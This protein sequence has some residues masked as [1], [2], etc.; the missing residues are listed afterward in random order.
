MSDEAAT[1]DR[2]SAYVDQ[3]RAQGRTARTLGF[4]ACL[5]GVMVLA[6]GRFRFG[7][8]AWMLWTGAAVVAVGWGLFVYALLRRL[9]WVRAHPFD[10]NG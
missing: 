2:Q 4:I 6:L 1:L 10:P 3:M 9:T 5:V 7:A 8:P